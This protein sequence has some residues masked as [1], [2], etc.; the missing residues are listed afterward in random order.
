[1]NIEEKKMLEEK[2]K[3]KKERKIALSKEQSELRRNYELA[4]KNAMV[5]P[6]ETFFDLPSDLQ[7]NKVIEDETVRRYRMSGLF[8]NIYLDNSGTV[9]R[10]KHHFID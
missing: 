9:D 2:K 10:R 4:K 7:D 6:I 1:M 3:E 8:L 5:L